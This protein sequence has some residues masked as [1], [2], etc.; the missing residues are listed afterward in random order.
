MRLESFRMQ[1]LTRPP[2]PVPPTP[3]IRVMS[4]THTRVFME[5]IRFLSCL[6]LKQS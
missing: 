6:Y 3:E 2:R 4:T 5:M 1:A